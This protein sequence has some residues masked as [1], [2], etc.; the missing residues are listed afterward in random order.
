MS[1]PADVIHD[2]ICLR[3]SVITTVQRDLQSR[4]VLYSMFNNS[5]WVIVGEECSKLCIF[6]CRSL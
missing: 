5:F 2:F 3:F 4:Y 1:S 6:D